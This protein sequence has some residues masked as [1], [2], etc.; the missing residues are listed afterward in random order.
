MAK[1]AL[2]SNV[3]AERCVLGSM[4]MDPAAAETALAGLTEEV[5]S[6]VDKRN[7]LVFKAMETL[8]AHNTRIDVQTV[9]DTLNNLK[10]YDDAGGSE[11][12]MELLQ[13]TISPD[14]IDHYIKIIKD[15]AVLRA[16][17]IQLQQIQDSYA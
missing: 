2:P 15:Q 6:D 16:Y 3:E 13:S 4:L 1:I 8:A 10:M 14:N 5:F 17:L 9:A 7:L 12:L 11:Y